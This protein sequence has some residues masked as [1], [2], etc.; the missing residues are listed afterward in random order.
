MIW[1]SSRKLTDAA[2][3]RRKECSLLHN[4][5]VQK[6]DVCML[7]DSQGQKE[8]YLIMIHYL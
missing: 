2:S 7:Y 4:P 5:L 8:A 1:P 3:S 6:G